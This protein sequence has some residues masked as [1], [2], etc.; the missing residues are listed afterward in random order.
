MKVT[1]GL[2]VPCYFIYY[3]FKE[4]ANQQLEIEGSA[5]DCLVAALSQLRR[6]RS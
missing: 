6:R 2:K 1:V 3:V 5:L 4:W